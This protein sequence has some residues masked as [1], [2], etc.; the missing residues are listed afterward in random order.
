MDC[1]SLDFYGKKD[2]SVQF[3]EDQKNTRKI[4]KHIIFPEDKGIQ[5]EERRGATGG[6]HPLAAGPPWVAPRAGVPTCPAPDSASSPIS[7]LR[8]P[9]PRRAMTDRFP[10]PLGGEKHQER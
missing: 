1:R 7:S 9:K 3:H 4:R 10:P 2:V 5:K 6:P 8:N